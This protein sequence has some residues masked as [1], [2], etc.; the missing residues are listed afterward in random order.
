M[1]KMSTGNGSASQFFRKLNDLGY[2][3]LE[4]EVASDISFIKINLERTTKDHLIRFLEL[5]L[6]VEER[7]IS[8]LTNRKTIIDFQL[9]AREKI[10]WVEAKDII[11]K[12]MKKESVILKA[13]LLLRPRDIL[14]GQCTN[15]I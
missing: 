8:R 13:L 7:S 5:A 15:I 4:Y 1:K 2:N 14:K 9:K 12:K 3:H 11:S 10:T 6:K